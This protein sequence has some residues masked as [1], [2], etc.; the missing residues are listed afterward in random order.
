MMSAP[1][2]TD[3]EPN[4]K[5]EVAP[6]VLPKPAPVQK[7]QPKKEQFDINNIVAL[8]DKKTP[9][10]LATKNAKAGSQNVKGLGAQTAMTADLVDSLRSQIMACWSPPVGAPKGADLVVDFDLL[11]NPDGSVAQPPQL[12]ANS[13]AA[14]GDPYA[15]AAAEAARRAIYT[16]APYK[17]PAEQIRTMAR[18]Q[19]VPFRP[20][21][22]DGTVVYRR[23]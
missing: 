21:P 17:L 14:A 22:N 20:K 1:N 3:S 16:C 7:T 19:S 5:I 8:L 18:N 4:R 2:P 10:A 23:S 6:T 15:R 9:A 11:L 13:R 12:T